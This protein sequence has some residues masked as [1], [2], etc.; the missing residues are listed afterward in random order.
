MEVRNLM[1][2]VKTTE[3][4]IKELIGEAVTSQLQP[5]LEKALEVDREKV[6]KIEVVD[7][8]EKDLKGGFKSMGHFFRDVVR[9][10]KSGG[11]N[12]TTELD[13]WET[14]V[15]A[16][17]T[18]LSEGDA[19]YA[20]HVIPTSFRNELMVLTE[21]TN[22]FMG[23]CTTIPMATNIIEIPLVWGFDQ[24]AGLVHGGVKWYWTDE[25]AEYTSS[26]PR[27]EKIQLKLKKL[28]GLCYLSDELIE[29]SPMSVE[30]LIKRGF[31]DGMN[32][33]LNNGF[34]RGT[35]AGQMQGVLNSP[36]LVSVTAETGQTAS[37]IMFE[38]VI[39]MYTQFYGRNGVWVANPN[40]LPQLASMSLTVGTGGSA[41]FMPAGGV[42]GKPY[43]TL[44]GMPIIFNDHC[45]TL[46]TVGDILLCDWSQYWIGRKAGAAEVKY[47]ESMHVMFLYDQQTL[48]FSTRLDGMV[49][50]PTYF[51]PPQST[52]TYRSP[53]VALAS[54]T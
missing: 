41:V 44:F 7:N 27:V 39:K 28:S 2:K 4:R 24:S 19:Q 13:K 48:K 1:D 52:S 32:F 53:F 14:H 47:A 33:A 46:G 3:D 29:D 34:I 25:L 30:A 54:R 40:C 38:N 15:K 35:G 16:A 45:S 8:F 36:A 21:E 43:N 20:G 23:L 50:W 26:R 22:D 17:G 51:T 11:R 18:G 10:D 12:M 49:S 31:Q 9:C 42:S 5:A 6:S 37:T